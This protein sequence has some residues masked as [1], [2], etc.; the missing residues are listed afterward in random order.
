V[1]GAQGIKQRFASKKCHE[2]TFAVLVFGREGQQSERTSRDY[3]CLMTKM[4]V[5]LQMAPFASFRLEHLAN[6]LDRIEPTGSGS[7]GQKRPKTGREQ[8]QQIQ[9]LY[10]TDRGTL[11]RDS[12]SLQGAGLL[13]A[14]SV[15]CEPA[16][17]P[18]A[19]I[20]R[21]IASLPLGQ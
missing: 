8:L 20:V 16:I 6:G 7:E 18:G 13:A 21:P 2:A 10:V 5:I 11:E 9:A 14:L 15:C 3:R 1:Q 4:N 19:P 17:D 12:T